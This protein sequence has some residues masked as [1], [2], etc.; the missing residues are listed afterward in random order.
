[1][2]N[3]K[4]FTVILPALKENHE[5]VKKKKKKEASNYGHDD[6]RVFFFVATS[7]LL[8]VLVLS[9]RTLSLSR[10]FCSVS[11]I[12]VKIRVDKV[13]PRLHCSARAT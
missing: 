5:R 6:V 1:M 13:I 10:S 7:Q 9:A 3:R 11:C 2:K 8:L 4:K 12:A